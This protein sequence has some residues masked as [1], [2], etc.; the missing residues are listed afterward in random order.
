MY[1]ICNNSRQDASVQLHHA[2]WET[3][4]LYNPVDGTVQTVSLQ[5]PVHI[6]ALRGV[7]V[8]FE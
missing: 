7:F 3:A 8:V 6:L 2:V 1:F 4:T 5:Q